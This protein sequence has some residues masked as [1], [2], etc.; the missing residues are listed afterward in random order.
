VVGLVVGDGVGVGGGGGD[1]VGDDSGEEL[2]VTH[3]DAEEL[4]PALCEAP[5]LLAVPLPLDGAF[6]PP[7]ED[8]EPL[9]TPFPPLWLDVPGVMPPPALMLTML[10][11]ICPRANTP[12]TTRTTAPA[13]AR[14][15][16][17]QFIT[18]PGDLR[19]SSLGPSLAEAQ[20][21]MGPR[22]GS[23]PRR[24]WV[25]APARAGAAAPAPARVLVSAAAECDRTVLKKDSDRTMTS[26]RSVMSSLRSSHHCRLSH[27]SA[28]RPRIFVKPSPTGSI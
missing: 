3:G 25:P 16:R 28:S 24:P 12:A 27:G 19:R 4:A 9:V 13:T 26:H 17:S 5:G 6:D 11:R 1:D 20:A 14:A 23:E 7:A 10:S 2:G 21:M 22:T 15:G 8:A 18:G